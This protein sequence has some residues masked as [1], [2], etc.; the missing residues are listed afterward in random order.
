MLAGLARTALLSLLA[1]DVLTPVRA[2]I[3]REE[4]SGGVEWRYHKETSIWLGGMVGRKVVTCWRRGRRQKGL[5][6]SAVGPR[7]RRGAE[8]ICSAERGVLGREMGG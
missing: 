8:R 4:L 7:E 1:R 3:L 2:L 6:D 5:G